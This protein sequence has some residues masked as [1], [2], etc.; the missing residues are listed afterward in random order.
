MNEDDRALLM[1]K[2]EFIKEL[3]KCRRVQQNAEDLLNSFL[4]KLEVKFKA[5]L[6]DI[7]TNAENSNNL[8][9]AIC[10]FVQYGEYDAESIWEELQDHNIVD[11]T[12]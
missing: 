12:D 1:T 6:A 11:I 10:C 2:S 3:K 8:E 5:E 9:E 4:E 7:K